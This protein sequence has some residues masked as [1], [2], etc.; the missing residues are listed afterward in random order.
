[1]EPVEPPRLTDVVMGTITLPCSPLREILDILVLVGAGHCL[2]ALVLMRSD[3]TT[4]VA[5]VRG[6]ERRSGDVGGVSEL[7]L[8]NDIVDTDIGTELTAV[9]VVL[10]GCGDMANNA[11]IFVDDCFAVGCC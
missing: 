1:M 8:D 11:S 3:G 2:F 10:T 7:L 4:E 6:R 9:V 5:I